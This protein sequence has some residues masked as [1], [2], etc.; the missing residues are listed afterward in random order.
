MPQESLPFGLN[1]IGYASANLGLGNTLRQFVTCFIECGI[2]IS[3]L[4]LDPGG[5]RSKFDNSFQQLT[6]GHAEELPYAVNLY[7]ISALTLSDF[8]LNPPKG[9]QID[10][11]LNVAFPWWELTDIPRHWSDASR[12]FDAIITGS[13]FVHNTFSTNVPGVP[14]LTAPHPV[15]IP[16]TVIP[17]RARF[18]LPEKVFLVYTGF[19]PHSDPSR[20]NP[21]SAVEAFKQAFPNTPDCHLVIKVNNASDPNISGKRLALL[22]SLYASVNS[23]VRIHL[24]QESLPYDDLLSLYASCDVFISLH[25]SEGLGLVPLEAMRLGKPVVATAWS[26]NMSYMNHLNSCLVSFEFTGIG[27]SHFYSKEN[28]GINGFWAEPDVNQA[29]AWLRK[30]ADDAQFRLRLGSR[31]S[32]D[33]Q[34]YHDQARKV[35]FVDELKAIWESRKFLP[36]RDRESLINRACESKMRFD[37]EKYLSKMNRF[38]LFAHNTKKILDS[39]LMWRFRK[40]KV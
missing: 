23:D 6:I 3:I 2:N 11:R 35:D 39:H 10:G 32:A 26:G 27:N 15:H 16:S 22:E 31:A 8:A 30:L 34:R 17:N 1:V 19:E 9:L 4:D 40:A 7:M 29:A 18:K 20:K 37:Y 12:V 36:Q 13:D 14:I 38:E 24:I 21:F 5:E 25:R 33:A 28:L